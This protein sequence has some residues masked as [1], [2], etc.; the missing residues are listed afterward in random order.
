MARL[1]R[2]RRKKKQQQQE[3]LQ[4]SDYQ[5]PG[6]KQHYWQSIGAVVLV[7]CWIAV[8][9]WW[10]L[11]EMWP[12]QWS[13]L[14]LWVIGCPVIVNYLAMRPRRQQLKELGHTAKVWSNN[15]P[16]YHQML[17]R[18][19][20][21]AGL[22]RAPEMYIVNEQAPY[23]YSMPGGAETIVATTALLD[24]LDTEEFQA[25]V[26]HEI[27]HIKSHHLRLDLAMTYVDNVSP[28]LKV[29]F[30]PVTAWRMLMGSWRDIIEYSAD[31]LALLL[32]KNPVALMRA[33]IKSAAAA[34]EQA[35]L[36]RDEIDA[37][38]A[39][40]GTAD[41]DGA[42]LERLF[43]INQFVK[44]QPNMQDRLQEIG[45]YLTSDEVEA[46]FEKIALI[47]QQV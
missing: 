14:P 42:Q 12:Y 47:S 2:K 37:Y 7:A 22:G 39:A 1:G 43:K 4:L 40:T 18:F 26:A 36:A 8:M 30:G 17:T 13:Y 31:R 10:Q 20:K 24:E 15:Y 32:T 11:H 46:A 29:A 33:I 21:L 34:D 9:V 38:L 23:I 27:G 25:L 16:Q 28:L 19:S 35:D 5:Y 44:S 45:A 6:E 3:T 41:T